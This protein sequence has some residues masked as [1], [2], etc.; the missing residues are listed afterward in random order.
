VYGDNLFE[1][2]FNEVLGAHEAKGGAATIALYERDELSQSGVVTIDESSRVTTF[3][4]K[5]LTRPEGMG[6]VNMGL[7][8]FEP[9]VLDYI[10]S[11]GASDFGRDI[12]PEML[13]RGERVFGVRVSGAGLRPI[14]TPELLKQAREGR[15][16]PALS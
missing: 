9:S 8:V 14:D 2:R 7:Y 13:R 4:E 5:P 11:E 10:P 16:D 6:L 3:V 15:G 1:C 12:F